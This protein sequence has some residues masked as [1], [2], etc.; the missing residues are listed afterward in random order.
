M[1]KYFVV[2]VLL[3]LG[4]LVQ[5]QI[6]FEGWRVH[7]PYYKNASV[8]VAGN[9]VYCGSNSGLFTYDAEDGSIER[10]S[11]V[12]G[13]SDVEVKIVKHNVAKNISVVIYQN[14]NIDLIDHA[15]NRIFNVPD[16]FM[17][18]IIGAKSINH[19]FFYQNR[20]YLA[21]SF[22]IVVL[23]L[24]KKQIVDSYQNLGLGGVQLA[25]FSVAIF[26]NQIFASAA[27]GIYVASLSA[28]NLSD[29]NFWVRT[30]ISSNSGLSAVYRGKL[31]LTIDGSLEVYDGISYQ[32]YGPT[33]GKIITALQLSA[34]ESA[35]SDLLIITPEL[36]FIEKG[37]L[38]PQQALETFRLD[39]VYD[40]RG[41]LCMVDDNYGLTIVNK[42]KGELDYFIPNGP[43]AKTFGKMLYAQGKLWVTGGSVNDRWDPLMYNGSKFFYY[44]NHSWF[45]F[46]ESEYP[47]LSGMSDF[48]DVRK[49]PYGN[50]MY[51][52]SF[53][54]GLIEMVGDKITAKFDATNSTLQRLS[55]VDT[56]YRPLLTGGMDFDNL[57]N[58][59]VSN[60]GVNKPLS[61]KTKS[62]WYSFNVGTITG[63]NE[64]GWLTCDDYNNKW[65]LSLRDR[66][67]LIY[68]D[69]G[70]PENIND[71]Q[72]KML[73]KEVGQGALPSNTI[74]C[75]TKDLR[76][77]IWV[78]S[79]QGLAIVSNPRQIFSVKKE[80]YDARQIIIKVGSN[81]E[82]F[83]GKEQINCIKVDPAN[84]KWIGT[85]NGVWLVSE[86]GYTVIK[87]FT[88]ANAPLLSNNVIEIGIDESSGEVFFGTEKGIISYMGDAS[89][90]AK[91]FDN[92]EIFPNPVRPDFTGSVSIR[93]LMNNATVKVTD[94]SGQLVYETTSN[95]GFASWDGRSMN[96]SRVSTGVYL[97]FAANK[98]GSQT[99][100]GK[101]LF[102]N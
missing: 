25:F 60:F 35:G 82:I 84:R 28:P 56:N 69:N 61:V 47:L 9:K 67:V 27:N 102:I 41:Y 81:F 34:Y 30:K 45:N 51:L 66:G 48:I 6:N 87:N 85:P 83:L 13:L 57:G 96:G 76:G 10:L 58:L 77:E 39:A 18:S 5:A 78:G 92:V 94:I 1:K 64:L 19:V 72:Y 37:E 42:A 40:K 2:L 7:L 8:T 32:S 97:I 36:I 101:L 23:D 65:V 90:G 15:S 52:S 86:D 14:T 54:G 74:L 70:T 43:V 80:D 46:R 24:D 99:H 89:A 29:F 11:K 20:A 71:D 33:A 75:V 91:G 22:G 17:R 26:E 59:W 21:C 53:G 62:G 98:D 31:Y 50:E 55:V 100:V 68:N 95:G 3:F 73:T 49:N 88:T 63:G 12:S 38:L 44:Q 16:V 93:G 4:V 79:S